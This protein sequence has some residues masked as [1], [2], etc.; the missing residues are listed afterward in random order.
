M[1]ARPEHA[2]R[3]ESAR[4][5]AIQAGKLTLDHFC[6]GVKVEKKGDG[7]P[8]T[9]ADRGAE[10]LL[11]RLIG[12]H[13]PEDAI[14]GEE[15]ENKDGTSGWR[16]ILDPIDGTKSFISGVPLYGTM[17][18]VEFEGSCDIGVCYFPGLDEG[19]YALTGN[20]AWSFAGSNEPVRAKVS[21]C[22]SLSESVLVTSEAETFSKRPAAEVY[23][24]LASSVYFART[25][26][27]A[28][29]YYLVATGRVEMM[30]DPI[31]SVWDAAAVKPVIEEAGGRFTD[32]AGNVNIEAG[33]AIGSNGLIHEAILEITRS[34]AGRFQ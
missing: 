28:Y 25:W 9:I 3:L 34:F 17:V 11:R 1:D 6:T 4:D 18:G 33:E 13:F 15:F 20:G 2:R 10:T 12:E 5:F 32:W 19:I 22:T 16:W 29:G 26:G 31:L 30:I 14:V 23:Q 8:L 27:D 21:G 7:S 24:Q